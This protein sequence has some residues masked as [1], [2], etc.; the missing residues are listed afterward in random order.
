MIKKFHL[1]DKGLVWFYTLPYHPFAI[2]VLA[3]QPESG[4]ATTQLILRLVPEF[5]ISDKKKS[6]GNGGEMLK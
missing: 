6:Y 4:Y 5:S 2:R 1:G 3:C